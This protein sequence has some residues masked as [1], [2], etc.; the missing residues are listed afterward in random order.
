M[1]I[2]WYYAQL[3]LVIGFFGYSLCRRFQNANPWVHL[4]VLLAIAFIIANCYLPI[5][6]YAV[7]STFYVTLAA[8]A[9]LW[10]TGRAWKTELHPSAWRR[11]ARIGVIGLYAVAT[12]LYLHYGVRHVQH[13][14]SILRRGEFPNASIDQEFTAVE[15][16]ARKLHLKDDDHVLYTFPESWIASGRNH[17][18]LWETTILGLV[19][20]REDAAGTVFKHSYANFY[21]A[22]YGADIGSTFPSRQQRVARLEK[23]L[24]GQHLCGLIFNEWD[25]G[26]GYSFYASA[27]P[28]EGRLLVARMRRTRQIEYGVAIPQEAIASPDSITLPPGSYVVSASLQ[29]DLK[30][31]ILEVQLDGEKAEPI[32]FPLGSVYNVIS[33][34]FVLEV[35]D[36]SQRFELRCR[37]KEQSL[38]IR[39]VQVYR[40]ESTP[41][42]LLAD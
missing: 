29:G 30:D 8:G 3:F 22:S 25:R 15:E 19:E 17:E 1:M 21:L 14:T 5:T 9:V 2:G 4:A 13:L 31:A 38:P 18:S 23:F 24:K 6:L 11:H 27:P 10:Q 7:Y 33:A 26:A 42:H 37:S 32:R 28:T 39:H 36:T 34:S 40:L 12:L 41:T 20:P 35:N 16:M